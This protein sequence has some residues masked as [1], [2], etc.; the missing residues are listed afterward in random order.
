MKNKE[1]ITPEE[2]LDFLHS[3]GYDCADKQVINQLF[4]TGSF[5][6][7]KYHL[8]VNP[9]MDESNELDSGIAVR[10]ALGIGLAA[11][12]AF[13]GFAFCKGLELLVKFGIIIP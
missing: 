11:T 2:L 10:L 9:F 8:S 3:Q 12:L 5:D 7:K 4:S 1:F 6:F 13:V